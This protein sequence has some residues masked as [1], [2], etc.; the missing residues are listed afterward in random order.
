MGWKLIHERNGSNPKLYLF[1]T[2]NIII[3]NN[4][5]KKNC[6]VTFDFR[7]KTVRNVDGLS[8]LT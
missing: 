1:V 7:I 5:K 8:R 3:I 2:N 6:T 4:N